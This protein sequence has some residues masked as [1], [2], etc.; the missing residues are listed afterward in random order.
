M[1]YSLGR[2]TLQ[3]RNEPRCERDVNL[4]NE[5]GVVF[6]R[7]ALTDLHPDGGAFLDAWS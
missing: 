4:T 5:H 2:L 3:I 7:R 1:D 6:E